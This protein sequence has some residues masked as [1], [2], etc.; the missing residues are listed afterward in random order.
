MGEQ[1]EQNLFAKSKQI[2]K[3]KINFNTMK[4]THHEIK[5]E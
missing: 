3:P 1:W 5:P 2:K 4:T